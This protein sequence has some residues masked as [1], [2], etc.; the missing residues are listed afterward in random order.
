ML[1]FLPACWSDKSGTH[2]LI[3]GIGF[4]IITTTNRPGVDVRDSHILGGEI[5]PDGF[6]VGWMNRH[7][8]AIDPLLASNAVVSV[9]ANPFGLTIKNYPV[10][11]DD[12]TVLNSKPREAKP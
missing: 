4:G 3:V 10:N 12:T 8:V 11:G 7:R 6:G 9:K 5:G 1:A 2:R